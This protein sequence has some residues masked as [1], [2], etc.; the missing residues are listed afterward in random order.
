MAAR[1]ITMYDVGTAWP[2]AAK[3]EDEVG[4]HHLS[5]DREESTIQVKRKDV[6][7]RKINLGIGTSVQTTGRV[8]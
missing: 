4:M 7:A 5:K 2:L 6:I 3:R 1:N 8:G